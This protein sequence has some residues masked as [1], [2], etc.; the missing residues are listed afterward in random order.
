M[1]VLHCS[2]VPHFNKPEHLND[3][4]HRQ[5]HM[6]VCGLDS[7][8]AR[9]QSNGMLTNIVSKL[10]RLYNSIVPLLGGEQKAL[11]EIPGDCLY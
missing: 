9:R 1:R 11:K 10:W 8:L 2:K 7:V 5:S 4:F 6:I 3:T